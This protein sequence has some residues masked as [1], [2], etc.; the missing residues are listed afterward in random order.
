MTPNEARITELEEFGR[1]INEKMYKKCKESGWKNGFKIFYTKLVNKPTMM[2]LSLN[3]GGEEESFKVDR[4]RFENGCF[5][6]GEINEFADEKYPFAKAIQD[7]FKNQE[8]ILKNFSR[9][10]YFIF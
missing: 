9:Y 1:G 5:E 2:I 3:P 4:E 6:V 8:E 7:L 10:S